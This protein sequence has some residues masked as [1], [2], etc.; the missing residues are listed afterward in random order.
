VQA[1][2]RGPSIWDVY[3]HRATEITVSNDTGDVG[4]NQYYLYKQGSAPLSVNRQL[5]IGM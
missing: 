4:D 1:E 2:G 3:T 5:L